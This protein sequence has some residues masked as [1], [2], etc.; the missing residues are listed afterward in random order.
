MIKRIFLFPMSS[1][2][3][4]FW[5]HRLA[6]VAFWSWLAAI[7]IYFYKSAIS[8]PYSS[9]ARVKYMV[10]ERSSELDCGNSAFGYAWKNAFAG[11]FS[12]IMF[13]TIF[14]MFAM[15]LAAVLPSVLYRVILYVTTGRG[16]YAAKK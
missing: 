12:S 15:Y 13:T 4:G 11:S 7:A 2:L 14:V 1:E 3:S 9:C 8:D 10:L 5:W 16:W 6:T